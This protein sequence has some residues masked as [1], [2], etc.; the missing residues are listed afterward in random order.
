MLNLDNVNKERTD[1]TITL[2]VR[3]CCWVRPLLSRRRI[4]A[5]G[6]KR[7]SAEDHQQRRPGIRLQPDIVP[8][9]QADQPGAQVVGHCANDTFKII[10]TRDS[11]AQ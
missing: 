4:P 3:L 10:Y 1:E 6:K 2:D 5:S 7:H 11:G 8:N 9:D